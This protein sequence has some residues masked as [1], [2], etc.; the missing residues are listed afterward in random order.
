LQKY[1]ILFGHQ[2]SESYGLQQFFLLAGPLTCCHGM[3]SELEPMLYSW[4]KAL[5]IWLARADLPIESDAIFVLAGET[6][7]KVYALEL[8]R[9]KLAK[10]IVL[11]VARF[12]IRGF[13]QLNLPSAVNLL[14]AAASIPAPQRH[15]FVSFA[16]GESR[17]E[18]LSPGRFGTLREV[19]ALAE[20]LRARPKNTSILVVSTGYHLYRVRLCCS[21]LLPKRTNIRYIAVPE[22]SATAGRAAWWSDNRTLWLVLLELVKIAWY[23]LLL[24]F[25]PWQ[26]HSVDLISI[27]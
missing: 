9:T 2:L 12:E 4:A 3:V 20:W 5:Y 13:S 7:R 6:Q 25:D 15:F 21:T 11:S 16:E 23:K 26:K 18:H 1:L 17:I 10:R 27:P 14:Q 8:H 24:T 22:Q 19:R